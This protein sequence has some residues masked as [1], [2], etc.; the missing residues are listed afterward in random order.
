MVDLIGKSTNIYMF[1]S[2]T[3]GSVAKLLASQKL[4][5]FNLNGQDRDSWINRSI[6]FLNFPDALFVDPGVKE[7]IMKSVTYSKA[8]WKNLIN[9]IRYSRAVNIL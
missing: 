3:S 8:W 1:D 5:G 4:S 2:V 7:R 6:I 9:R